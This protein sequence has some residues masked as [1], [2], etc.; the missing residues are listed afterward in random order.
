[1]S[2]PTIDIKLELQMRGVE[3]RD[4]FEKIDLAK[5]LA[6]A[7]LRSPSATGGKRG[8]V[9]PSE[10]PRHVGEATGWAQGEGEAETRTASADDGSSNPSSSGRPRGWSA[11]P[12]SASSS[13]RTAA[14]ENQQEEENAEKQVG[15]ES[16]GEYHARCVSRAVRMGKPA[17]VRELNA[18]GIAHSRLSDVN[19]LARQYASAK[20]EA[21]GEAQAREPDLFVADGGLVQRLEAARLRS[22]GRD[23]LT[24]RLRAL[25]VDFSTRDSEIDLALLLQKAGGGD[26]VAVVTAGASK[27]SEE[28]GEKGSRDGDNDERWSG[29]SKRGW[30]WERWAWGKQR[31]RGGGVSSVLPWHDGRREGDDDDEDDEDDDSQEQEEGALEGQAEQSQKLSEYRNRGRR[32]DG[33]AGA[34][35][36]QSARVRDTAANYVYCADEASGQDLTPQTAKTQTIGGVSGGGSG[37]GMRVPLQARAGR[38]SSREL[39]NSLDSLGI[40]YP[41]PSA[42]SELEEAF[43]SAVLAGQEDNRKELSRVGGR[44]GENDVMRLHPFSYP[45]DDGD[46]DGGGDEKCRP[47]LF[48]TYHG[49][50][51]WARRLTFDDV[52][53]ELRFRGVKFEPNGEFSDL[54]RLL[55]DQVLAEEELME[56]ESRKGEMMNN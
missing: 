51:R 16:E 41:I 48:E 7:R 37:G 22:L 50:L 13:S 47:A 38:M 46:E 35:K 14:R 40:A 15:E 33:R 29:G 21:R 5:R 30:G 32:V 8:N 28:E 17:I 25:K 20:V 4:A 23:E 2:V 49:A 26:G 12:K 34:E 36:Q 10:V 9:F 6:E 56:A 44:V 42:R 52:L 24:A 31:Q 27:V 53:E 19:V 45:R 3:H 43:I 39:M 1:M 54:T 11:T 55:A 18:M